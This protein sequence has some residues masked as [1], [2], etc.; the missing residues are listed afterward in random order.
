LEGALPG[1]N[2]QRFKRGIEDQG[3][4]HRTSIDSFGA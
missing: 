1:D 4:S 3:V 2:V